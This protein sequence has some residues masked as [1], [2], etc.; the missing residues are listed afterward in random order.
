VIKSFEKAHMWFNIAYANGSSD[1]GEKR[2]ASEERMSTQ[3]IETARQMAKRC[4][5][6]NY[7]QCE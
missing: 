6:S 2:A 1:A 5:E 7:K 3:Q 4:L